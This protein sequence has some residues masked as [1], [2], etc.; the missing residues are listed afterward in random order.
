M[1][2]SYHELNKEDQKEYIRNLMVNAKT[3]AD[4]LRL[5]VVRDDFPEHLKHYTYFIIHELKASARGLNWWLTKKNASEEYFKDNRVKAS[6]Y[7]VHAGVL[8]ELLGFLI[9]ES[10]I[11][12][13][14]EKG[15]V[16][17]NN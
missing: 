1:A 14:R 8:F 16:F 9:G 3:W 13:L 7:I 12:M 10:V 2:K 15:F 4:E 6:N 11:D 17:D 5:L